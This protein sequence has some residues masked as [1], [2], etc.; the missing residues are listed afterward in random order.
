MS[1]STTNQIL[2]F[3]IPVLFFC[4]LCFAQLGFTDVT[5]Q[6]GIDHQFKVFEGLFGGGACVF[7]L[8]N[9]G[10]QDLYITSGM[11]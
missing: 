10:F 5:K 4:N 7:D 6:A 3:L 9:D 1:R 8:N 2:F 11:N